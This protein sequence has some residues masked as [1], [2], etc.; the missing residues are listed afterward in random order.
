MSKG[1]TR[2]QI[3][4]ERKHKKEEYESRE[5]KPITRGKHQQEQEG[6]NTEGTLDSL[7][8][9]GKPN[10]KPANPGV[11]PGKKRP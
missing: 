6:E 10:P 9:R 5:A 7:C 11:T 4:G 1:E 8:M 3:N 2:K